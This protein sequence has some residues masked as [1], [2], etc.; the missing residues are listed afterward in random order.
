V[1]L[2]EE[3]LRTLARP[4]RIFGLLDPRRRRTFLQAL[5]NPGWMRDKTWQRWGPGG[6]LL[7]AYPTYEDYVGHQRSKLEQLDLSEYDVEYPR[8]LGERLRAHGLVTRGMTVL[9]LAARLGS[10][11]KAFLDLG[12]FAVGLDLNPGPNNKYVVYGDFH[13]IQF[14]DGS[15]D[16]VFTN[17]LDHVF[18]IDRVLREVRRVLKPGGLLVTEAIRGTAEGGAPRA[19]ESFFWQKIDDLVGLVERRG[20]ALL[21]RRPFQAPWRGDHLCWRRMEAAAAEVSRERERGDQAGRDAMEPGER[22]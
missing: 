7:R 16:V 1:V 9:C 11:V 4:G 20:F 13:A 18:D 12:C 6:F 17:S 5:G 10:E 3:T 8:L 21:W 14:A 15:V 22:A 19:Y 2:W